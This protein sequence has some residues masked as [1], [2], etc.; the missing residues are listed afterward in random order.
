MKYDLTEE[1]LYRISLME[2]YTNTIILIRNEEHIVSC[3]DYDSCKEC[4]L[5]RCYLDSIDT[6][7][8]SG[9]TLCAC[10]TEGS[11]NRKE[12]HIRKILCTS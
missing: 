9:N 3:T 4:S 1:Q 5:G 12:F 8:I 2:L 10:N 6:E 11:S 7:N